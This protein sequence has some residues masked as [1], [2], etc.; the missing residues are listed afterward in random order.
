M[1]KRLAACL[2]T[3]LFLSAVTGCGTENAP[4][5]TEEGMK[6]YYVSK[7][8]TEIIAADYVPQADLSDTDAMITELTVQLETIPDMLEYEAPISGGIELLDYTLAEQLLTL[9]F[10]EQYGEVEPTTEILLRAAMVRT[11]SQIPGVDTI[12]FQVEGKPLTDI[13]DAVVGNMTADRFIYNAGREINTY[14]K[15]Q[16]TLY[17]ADDTGAKLMPV[18]RTVVYNSNILMERLIVEQLISGPKTA[19]N[20]LGFYPTINPACGIVGIS[21]RDGICYV[22]LDEN[23]LTQTNPVTPQAT[24]YSIVNSLAEL[25]EVT[26]VQISVNGDTSRDFMDAMP[27]S[28]M[29]TRNLDI[30][31]K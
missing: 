3:L 6:I 1:K 12:A 28:S 24:I 18:Y 15:V 4:A 2:L 5:E 9:N 22:N 31:V 29:Y 13:H 30:I 11:Y 27:L 7:D 17:F 10:S 20:D 14:E 16:L 8:E 23:F 19:G 21:I 25:A 26:R